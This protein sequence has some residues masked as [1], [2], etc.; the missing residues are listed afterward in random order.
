MRSS[1][2]RALAQFA[3]LQETQGDRLEIAAI[4]TENPAG[5]NQP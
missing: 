1:T 5:V 4:S 3:M 2:R